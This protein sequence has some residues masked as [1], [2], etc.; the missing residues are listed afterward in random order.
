[1]KLL[2]LINQLQRLLPH[3]Q[4]QRVVK[5]DTK[6][7]IVTKTVTGHPQSIDRVYIVNE[8]TMLALLTDHAAQA[9]VHTPKVI[10][11]QQDAEHCQLSTAYEP[12][13]KL[14]EMDAKSM[15]LALVKIMKF[16]AALEPA[17]DYSQLPLGTRT[18]LS[19]IL[20]SCKLVVTSCFKPMKHR[21]LI[22][23][24][25]A[26]FIWQYM[27]S[28]FAQI[29]LGVTHRDLDADN[30]MISQNSIL[31][32]DWENAVI[33]DPLFD[34]AQL[35]RLYG[36][37]LGYDWCTEFCLTPI[38]STS[39]IKRWQALVLYGCLQSL[40]IDAP[41]SHMYADALACANYF[42]PRRLTFYEI[43][44]RSIFWFLGN[45]YYSLPFLWKKPTGGIVLCYH[46]VGFDQWRY[47][48]HPQ[49]LSEHVRFLRE[50]FNLTDLK[51]VV[52]TQ[53][54]AALTFDDGYQNLLTHAAPTLET[55]NTPACVFVLGSPQHANRTEL[56][57]QL[58][59]LTDTQIKKLHDGGWEI[60]HH[61]HTHAN[62]H[63]CSVA[64]LHTE[65]TAS[66]KLAAKRLGLPLRFFA[67]PK[68]AYSPQICEAVN[69]A[70]FEAAFT[71]DNKVMRSPNPLLLHR[72]ALERETSVP[73]LMAMLSP[74]GLLLTEWFW[75]ALQYKDSLVQKTKT[76]V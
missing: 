18:P 60:G 25:F 73:Q 1:M 38:N 26:S 61:T 72:V 4:P 69:Q 68:G 71:V 30:I 63:S 65:I 48:T 9:E 16:M 33:S 70:G 39:E 62:L 67:Y 8:A 58:P 21:Q 40:V 3:S 34:S 13:K 20:N 64:Q 57:N 15:K 66:R 31:I 74:L 49:E 37:T 17:E 52:S 54:G 59:L 32:T 12:G 6:R 76:Y 22:W 53:T 7:K 55:T 50:H 11:F 46:S 29:K 56:D 2:N 47:T 41:N 36:Q 27:P 23:Q 45:I 28:L 51:T 75:I 10:S 5:I 42:A 14:A 44:S 24:L 35:P 43:V 19:F